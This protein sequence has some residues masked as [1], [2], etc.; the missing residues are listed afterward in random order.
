MYTDGSATN[1]IRDGGARS[2]IYLQGG[3]QIEN[4]AATGKHCTNYGA[5]VKALEQG[6]KAIDDLTDQTTDV[7]FLTDSRSALDA[8]HNQSEPHLSRILH[9]ILGKRRVVLQWIPA[10]CGING[11]EM[12][13]KLAKKGATLTQHDNPI[14]FAEKK[15][16]IKH[17]FKTK[18]IHDN[19]HKLDRAGQVIILRLRTGHN[20]LNSHMHKTMKL[21]QSPLCTCQTENQTADHILQDCPTFTNLRTQIWPDGISLHQQL[22]GTTED[23]RR[24]VGFI[25]QTGL[26]V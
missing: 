2:I 5:E 13:D 16:I 25:Q 24:T 15:R 18:K 11:N 14:T 23:L 4:S 22:H 21:V 9:S 3:Q 17:S 20:R 12:A 7:V 10:H 8:L 26:S 19:Y 1:A 6:A